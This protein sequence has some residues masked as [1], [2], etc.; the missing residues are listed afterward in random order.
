MLQVLVLIDGTACYAGFLLAPKKGFGQ[1]GGFFCPTL[2]RAVYAVLQFCSCI[3]LLDMDCLV[4]IAAAAALLETVNPGCLFLLTVLERSLGPSPQS[5]TQCQQN[6]PCCTV[7]LVWLALGAREIPYVDP[8][9]ANSP[10]MHNRIS[11]LILTSTKKSFL[12]CAAI[13]TNLEPKLSFL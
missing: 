12:F 6:F 8:A 13:L 2:K 10:S 5:S 9:P 1:G 4:Y 7:C 11:L 3:T